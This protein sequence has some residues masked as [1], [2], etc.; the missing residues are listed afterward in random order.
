MKAETVYK[1]FD[2][3]DKLKG[4]QNFKLWFSL[5]SDSLA[6]LELDQL[7]KGEPQTENQ[8]NLH[9][10]VLVA[11]KKSV[12]ATI[13]AQYLHIKSTAELT[14]E[15][16]KR[17]DIVTVETQAHDISALFDVSAHVTQFDKTLSRLEEIYADLK[18]RG[19]AVPDP[20][21]VA[22]IQNATPPQYK[23]IIREY[24][25]YISQK[26]EDEI[27]PSKHIEPKPD[28]IFEKLRAAWD[29]YTVSKSTQN[30]RGLAALFPYRSE[31]THPYYSQCFSGHS[32]QTSAP[33]TRGNFRGRG[34]GNTSRGNSF[35]GRGSFRG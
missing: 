25:Q 28:R 20:I 19:T 5:V 34:R 3:I 16:K 31:A 9:A 29:R 11:L 14:L 27:D 4:K 26:N 18:S 13:I 6:A 24:L 23:Q 15:L 33:P 35:R 2:G 10:A 12:E 1:A 21:Y 8:T 17:F 30:R 7:L 32:Q 22:A